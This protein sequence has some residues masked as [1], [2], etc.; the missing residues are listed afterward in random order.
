M[1]TREAH[2]L[3]HTLKRNFNVA[4][5]S[6]S[7]S[8][9]D[10]IS[11]LI[12]WLEENAF[13]NSDLLDIK[14][15]KFGGLGVFWSLGPKTDPENDSLLLRIPKLAVLSP[16]NSFIYSLMV[17]FQSSSPS[18][19]FT[20]GMH[21]LVLAYI[22]EVSAKEHSP[23]HLYFES[24]SDEADAIPICLWSD[25]EKKLFFNSECDLLGMLDASE[26]ANFYLECVAFAKVMEP[27]V[28]I[29]EVLKS[30][31]VEEN[32]IVAQAS[33]LRFGNCVQNVISRAFTVDKYYGLSLVPG[34]DLFNH[35]S[36]IILKGEMKSREN[37]HFV[38]DDDEDLC[39]KCGEIGCNHLEE[40]GES[41]AEESYNEE[42][43]SSDD[44]NVEE[45]NSEEKIN[46]LETHFESESEISENVKSEPT[47]QTME[48]EDD[49]ELSECEEL[50]MAMVEELEN[51]DADTDLDDEEV[52][53]LSLSENEDQGDF[54]EHDE[55]DE[56]E[57][58]N[59][60]ESLDKEALQMN[61]AQADLAA[62]LQDGSKCCDIVLKRPADA[63][64]DYELFNT[65]GNELSNPFLLQRY[66]FICPE[67]P[68]MS[69]NLTIPMFAHLKKVRAIP[70]NK[71]KLKAKID[72]YEEMGFE[73]VNEI[74]SE[75]GSKARIHVRSH[76][77]VNGHDHGH[78]HNECC[79]GDDNDSFDEEDS[80]D[81]VESWPLSPRIGSDG[82]PTLQTVAL[83]QLLTMPYKSFQ[84]EFLNA[85]SERKLEKRVFNLLVFKELS[86]EGRE[87]LKSWVIERLRRYKDTQVVEGIRAQMINVMIQDE[88]R[89][90]LKALS[91]LSKKAMQ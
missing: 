31:L 39:P 34:A 20:Q 7:A 76:D 8:R 72:W 47:E 80:N 18:F 62:E 38:C 53:T 82:K 74:C 9:P 22:Y 44:D 10:K 37:V 49:K 71:K 32:E 64:Y 1:C 61:N 30:S 73:L 26:L 40:D 79:G 42:E 51:D 5:P 50:T 11:G 14:K 52:S 35:L 4:Y 12:R 77:H 2:R 16:K 84:N 85:P 57:V 59:G 58:M 66:G 69:C 6:M 89:L 55:M 83:I 60:D 45:Q 29:P 78:D 63:T 91:D 25:S 21:S 3:I 43:N 46:D 67:N 33:L 68:N 27:F 24:F 41:D 54:Y 88:K 19:D 17:D 70:K 13:W 87:I 48:E 86:S 75:A 15:S 90:L 28:P 56:D 81:I 36:P 23:W 65:Y